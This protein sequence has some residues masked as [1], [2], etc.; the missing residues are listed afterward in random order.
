M[1]PGAVEKVSEAL[2]GPTALGRNSTTSQQFWQGPVIVWVNAEIGRMPGS[3]PVF[4]TS[5]R[6]KTG[7]ASVAVNEGRD[8]ATLYQT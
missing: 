8:A 6:P 1:P 2:A 4:G 7:F 3:L 5:A